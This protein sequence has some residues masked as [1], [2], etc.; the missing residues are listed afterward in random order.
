M[1]RILLLLCIFCLPSFCLAQQKITFSEL[2]ELYRKNNPTLQA[3][4]AELKVFEGRISD[5]RRLPNPS[6]NAAVESLS[7]GSRETETSVSVSQEL[8]LNNTRRWHVFTLEHQQNAENH[9]LSFE[10]RAG[11]TNL[12]NNFGR[13]VMLENDVAALRKVLATIEDIEAR[14]L[15][16]LKNGDVSEVDVMRLTAEKQKVML[17]IGGLKDEAR[18]GLRNVTAE[19]GIATGE[20]LL[21]FVMPK[22]PETFDLEK[23]YQIALENRDDLKAVREKLNAGESSIIAAKRETRSP[24]TI[25]GGYKARNGGFNG[26]ILGVSAPLPFN[27]RNK[28]KIQEF[29]AENEATKLHIIATEK[30]LAASLQS[31]I[32]KFA[33]LSSREKLLA[34]Q[35][36]EHE[37][38]AGIARFNFEEGETGLL[39][40]FDAVRNQSDLILE[41]N[42]TI[43]E[44]WFVV[45][46]L[47]NL[48]GSNLI[49]TGDSE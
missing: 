17:L 41:L 47:E 48:T 7:N 9:L 28:G 39:E 27:N 23:L 38:I 18:V 32:E 3:K 42:R 19:L 14:S 10:M 44:S 13:A 1:N 5:A 11:L 45:F 8:D 31:A 24:L 21:D 16:R 25:E 30:K 33:F 20:V 6:L 26:F 46:E 40:I 36:E 37:K 49:L 43:M 22:L 35:I 2:E 4:N 34:R 29:T 12:K 15:I